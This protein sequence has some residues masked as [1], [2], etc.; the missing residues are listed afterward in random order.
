[1][2]IKFLYFFCV[3]FILSSCVSNTVNVRP[4][5]EEYSQL[6]DTPV[7]V[8]RSPDIDQNTYTNDLDQCIKASNI[9]VDRSSKIGVGI[10]SIWLTS[11]LYSIA[12]AS[13]V[14]AP[15]A[16][17][18]GAVG[19]IVGGSTIVVTKATEEFREYAGLE[20]CLERLGHEVIFYDARKV[21]NK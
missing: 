2:W 12:V 15:V 5:S 6:I 3:T 1:M 18:A 17:A 14:F 20:N 16:V 4:N 13:G 19:T 10:G 11:G 21:K 8:K 9:R 7:Y